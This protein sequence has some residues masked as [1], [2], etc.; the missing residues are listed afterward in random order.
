[1]NATLLQDTFKYFAKY[2]L[3]EGVMKNFQRS[4][5]SPADAYDIYK[6]SIAA[7]SPNSLIS[8]LTDY[9]FGADI[10]AVRQRIESTTGY[11]LFID[12]GNIYS[13][14]LEPMKTQQEEFV[15][16]I[17]IAKKSQPDDIDPVQEMI[18]ADTTMSMLSQ[19]KD[20][21]KADAKTNH[22][23]KYLTFPADITPWFAPDLF[24]SIGWTMTFKVTG[25][26]MI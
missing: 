23:L 7:I 8:G 24:N 17:T 5:A 18:I 15:I 25:Y 4:A 21:V 19:L 9:I 6:A 11:Y 13:S 14:E 22:F 20:L 10:M 1:M 26:S 12:Y 16:S 2:P 3:M